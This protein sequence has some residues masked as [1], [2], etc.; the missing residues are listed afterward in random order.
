MKRYR[1][2]DDYPI[3]SDDYGFGASSYD[4]TGLI[5]SAPETDEEADAYG[6]IYPYRADEEM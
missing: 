4:M 3:F 5:P 2:E 6:D 1:D